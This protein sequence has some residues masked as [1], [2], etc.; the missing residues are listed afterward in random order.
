MPY[1]LALVLSLMG[2]SSGAVPVPT[3]SIRTDADIRAAVMRHAPAVR[4]CYETEG[5][6]RN[7]SLAGS[8]EITVTILPTG[9]VSDV[10]VSTVGLKGVGESE[11]AKCLAGVARTW[12]FDRGP[13]I[14]ETVVFPFDLVRNTPPN[15]SKTTGQRATR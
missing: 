5:L 8:V 10:E 13:Y 2:V 6:L 4:K 14:I 7:P 15:G 3:D 12:R 1:N 9:V 11:V